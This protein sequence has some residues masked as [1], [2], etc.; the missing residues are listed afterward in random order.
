M[1]CQE[2]YRRVD[3]V[4]KIDLG[5]RMAGNDFGLAETNVEIF[6]ISYLGRSIVLEIQVSFQLNFGEYRFSEAR[7]PEADRELGVLG[8]GCPQS[9]NFLICMFGMKSDR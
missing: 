4:I 1:G 3:E 9:S 6:L 2:V 7:G 8:G 5:I